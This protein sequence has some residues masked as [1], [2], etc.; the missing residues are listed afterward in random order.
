MV[1][2]AIQASEPPQQSQSYLE[3]NS[4]G[5]KCCSNDQ[6]PKYTA[7]TAH[8]E[9][10]SNSTQAEHWKSVPEEKFHL[11]VFHLRRESSRIHCPKLYT[12][13]KPLFKADFLSINNLDVDCTLLIWYTLTYILI[14]QSKVF[15]ITIRLKYTIFFFF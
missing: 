6:S 12:I 9:I 11:K 14:L 4:R 15:L 7:D 8:Q 2:A 5:W 3:S 10:S 13:L 1:Q